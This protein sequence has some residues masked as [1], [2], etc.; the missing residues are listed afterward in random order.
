MKFNE[1]VELFQE[2]KKKKAEK[3]EKAKK[4][5]KKMMKGKGKKKDSGKEEGAY[6]VDKDGKIAGWEKARSAAIQKNM[7]NGS[8]K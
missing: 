7:K 4:M 8:K 3:A 6:D 2:A 1:L 5:P